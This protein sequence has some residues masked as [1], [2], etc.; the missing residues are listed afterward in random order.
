MLLFKST[1]AI[2]MLCKSLI[3]P[4]KFRNKSFL[5]L[6]GIVYSGGLNTEHW[7]TE[8]FEVRIPNGLWKIGMRT[9]GIK[10]H[11]VSMSQKGPESWYRDV[12]LRG[13]LK[14]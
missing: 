5:S 3:H 11:K 13:G 2:V 4:L 12:R 8:P 10:S 9:I 6:Q 1:V 7:N 14:V